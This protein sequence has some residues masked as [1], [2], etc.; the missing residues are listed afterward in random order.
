MEGLR[1][2]RDHDGWLLRLAVDA[3]RP[4]ALLALLEAGFDPDARVRVEDECDAW[5][6]PLY[7]CV[8][9]HKHAMAGML[10]KFGADANGQVYASGTPLAEAY[11]QRD[12]EMIALLV[13]HG[14]KPNASMAGL[15]RR[16]DLAL[17]LLARHGDDVLPDDGFSSGT[18]AEQ[19][20]G[21][22]AKGGD[23][24]ILRLA[25]SR[26]SIPDGD[27]RWNGLLAVP[28]GFW[29]HWYGPWCHLEWD[30]SGYLECFRLILSKSG[31]PVHQFR[32][33][34]SVLHEIVKMGDHVRPEER[35]AFAEAALAAGARLDLR[36]DVFHETPGELAV[37]LGRGE[38]AGLLG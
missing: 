22:A 16:M 23:P 18:V 21:A 26:V 7:A 38:L 13:R 24:A 28:L 3:D 15:Y 34:M 2:P 36:D 17:E 10:L 8:R 20:L 29:N 1:Q 9:G 4:D 32:D 19:L 27:R 35:A 14:G 5:G 31:P 30:R 12:E 11:G 25:V 6:M 33:G 37:R